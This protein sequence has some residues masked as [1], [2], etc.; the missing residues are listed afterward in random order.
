MR[1]IVCSLAIAFNFF[2]PVVWGANSTLIAPPAVTPQ[3]VDVSLPTTQ[4]PTTSDPFKN[5]SACPDNPICP[6]INGKLP[7]GMTTINCPDSC[8]VERDVV[9]VSRNPDVIVSVK[10]NPQCPAGYAV[11]HV[12]KVDKEIV[13]KDVPEVVPPPIN[14]FSYTIFLVNG[15]T[16]GPSPTAAEQNTRFCEFDPWYVPEE[17]CGTNDGSCEFY[18]I[19]NPA[20]NRANINNYN[21]FMAKIVFKKKYPTCNGPFTGCFNWGCEATGGHSTEFRYIP[22]QCTPPPGFYTTANMVPTGLIC[23]RS[24]VTWQP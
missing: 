20:L 11:K 9:Y 2:I 10:K 15:Y 6:D 24:K 14:V 5:L 22:I 21:G 3:H 4:L 8:T 1:H 12:Y 7:S 16:C 23:S 13:W 18:T 19:N 17:L